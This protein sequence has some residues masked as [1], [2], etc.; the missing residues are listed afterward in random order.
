[1]Q[2]SPT[3]QLS[4]LVGPSLLER[5]G[6]F[7]PYVPDLPAYKVESQA[8]AKKTDRENNEDTDEVI[9]SVLESKESD[10]DH[11][12]SKVTKNVYDKDLGNSDND[13]SLDMCD[14]NNDDSSEMNDQ[15]NEKEAEIKFEMDPKKEIESEE[16]I[17]DGEDSEEEEREDIK[18][19]EDSEEDEGEETDDELDDFDDAN[20]LRSFIK[21]MENDIVESKSKDQNEVKEEVVSSPTQDQQ[22]KRGRPA[23]LKRPIKC[24]VCN[25]TFKKN[26]TFIMHM[27]AH[28]GIKPFACQHCDFETARNQKLTQH[29]RRRH[30]EE[31][32]PFERSPKKEGVGYLFMCEHCPKTFTRKMHLTDHMRIHNGTMF[33]CDQCDFST[34]RLNILHNHISSKHEEHTF[35]CDQC[36]RTFG[37]KKTLDQHTKTVHEKGDP[38]TKVVPRTHYCDQCGAECTSWAKLKNHERF[39]HEL[40]GECNICGIKMETESKFGMHMK[41]HEIGYKAPIPHDYPC[42]FPGCSNVYS[43]RG[44]LRKHKM[45]HTGERPFECDICHKTFRQKVNME[46]HRRI[47]T[48]EKPNIC[49]ICGQAF[50]Q[51][52]AL[53]SHMSKHNSIV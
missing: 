24:E 19:G 30:P 4:A 52:S 46:S 16:D 12:K 35:L 8:E 43:S 53:R 31:Y 50:T 2:E 39:K 7:R 25:K 40:D 6:P 48:G 44:G 36:D 14:Q 42:R 5:E 41:T 33:S 1:M 47:H 45:S 32:V 15:D 20:E 23:V 37:L 11:C 10:T 21:G 51:A 27:N 13:G 29:I 38:N 9:P 18:D 49:T 34:T 22:P 28:N 26:A 3:K 17:K